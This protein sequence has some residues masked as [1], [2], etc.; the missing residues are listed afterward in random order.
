[1]QSYRDFLS[2]N[3]RLISFGVL[4]SFS[5]AFGQTFYIS[6]FSAEIR[7]TFSLSHGDFGA[8]Y[9]AGTLASAAFL[10]WTGKMIDQIDLRVYMVAICLGLAAACVGMTLAGSIV[11]LAAVVFC[12][13]QFGQGLLSH[14]SS[15]TMARY[16]Y[17]GRGKAV[18]LAA[19]GFPLGEAV[20]PTIA[21]AVALAIG[22]RQTWMLSAVFIIVVLIPAAMILLRG[23]RD[24]DLAYRERL[25]T[26][27]KARV[28]SGKRGVADWTRAQVL[29][30]KR[31]YLALPAIL[32]P[33]FVFTG[34]FFHQVHLVEL[35]GWTMESLA[36]SYFAYSAATIGASIWGGALIDR[37]GAVRLLPWFLLP[38]V[39]AVAILIIDGLS[40]T[41]WP[42]MILVGLNAGLSHALFSAIWAEIYGTRY[43]GSLK[44]LS[45][46]LMVFSS[47]LSPFLL[48]LFF[49]LGADIQTLCLLLMSYMVV[50]IG[51]ATIA[52]RGYL[53]AGM[54]GA[55][56]T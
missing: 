35:Q 23:H 48:G 56:S 50:T 55:S 18:G 30:D 14:T 32:A 44:A 6:L 24:R 45:T 2:T 15:T 40:W 22:W 51:L 17:P 49:D 34:L 52:M 31:F 54:G 36:A 7:E 3:G 19:L 37:V 5:S 26:E 12:L 38:L 11:S 42:Y 10:I 29:R 39:S 1:M 33:S 20:F 46:A 27:E 21:V 25:A 43:L 53:L 4:A 47:A 9:S 28:A 16:V 8:V 13:R 41:V